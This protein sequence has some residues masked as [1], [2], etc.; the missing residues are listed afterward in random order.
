VVIAEGIQLLVKEVSIF[1]KEF[2]EK[3]DALKTPEAKA[4][5]MDKVVRAKAQ[6]LTT[7]RGAAGTRAAAHGCCGE[8]APWIRQR[9]QPLR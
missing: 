1:G 9:E 7:L 6:W 8:G 2:Q 5:E 4:S 3:L